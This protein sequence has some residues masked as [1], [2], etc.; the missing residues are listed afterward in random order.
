[1]EEQAEHKRVWD[2]ICA[3]F[4]ELVELLGDA[5]TN[6]ADFQSLL[7][8]AL[9]DL[10]LAITPPT[11]DQVLVGSIDRTR[12]PALKACAIL[13]LG[14]G[15]FP[16]LN[17][18]GTIFTD[19]DRRLLG[20]RKID[21]DPDTQRQLLDENF[22]AYIAFT[23]ASEHL[24]LTRPAQNKP[25]QPAAPS[26][27]WLRVLEAFP[28]LRVENAVAEERLPLSELS[29][30]RQLL[31]G[32]MRWVR[33]PDG[34]DADGAAWR[35]LY[36]WLARRERRGDA[37]DAIRPL[38][39]KALSYCNDAKVNPEQ[40]G[41]LFAE[42][43]R[44]SI[45]QLENFRACPY[46]HFAL[47]G[48]G[49]V[50][51]RRQRAGPADLSHIYHQ[52]LRELTNELIQSDMSWSDLGQTQEALTG[53]IEQAAR[54]L[55][56]ELLLPTSRSRYLIDRIAQGL[57]SIVAGQRA[58][59]DR[60]DFR[61][62]W[63]NLAFGDESVGSPESAMPP[64][65]IRSSGGKEIF[66]R[67]KIDRVDVSPDGLAAVIDYRL[68]AD[69]LDPSA[70]FHGVNLR[71]LVDLLALGQNG[72]HLSK[73]PIAPVAAFSVGLI[74]KIEEK[75]PAKCPSADDPKFHLQNKPRGI[76]DF[77]A[78][79]RLDKMI[80]RRSD[81]L[82]VMIKGDETIGEPNKSDAVEPDQLAALLKH[83]Q[84]QIGK[85]ADGILTGRIEVRPFRIGRQTPCAHCELRDVCRIDP[86]TGPYE[87]LNAMDRAEMLRR[88]THD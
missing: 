37:L 5:P 87:T 42:P 48:L 7:D 35:S 12:T 54:R 88:V 25:N 71:L 19:N 64:L 23:R 18:E 56:S 47:H 1:L 66:I 14:E 83:T 61:P 20:D 45:R 81:V 28:D 29:T 11:V 36:D 73:Q 33:K 77:S 50:P 15:Q 62:R 79:R 39:W 59:G 21:L 57:R 30:P 52:V 2:E 65:K 22:L 75:D 44:L 10:Q 43:L 82:Q 86:A 74:R 32:L 68:H 17:S 24:L 38:A 63:T 67:G 41:R 31:G 3:L 27:L 70:T 72:R 78:V 58:A 46:R 51:R 76:F 60:G 80:E 26:P 69:R 55:N 6:L 8:L 4:D 49:L 84:K 85:L 34:D 13:G 53:L 16:K 9:E 40:S